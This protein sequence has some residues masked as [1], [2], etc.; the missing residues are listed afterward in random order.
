MS[1]REFEVPWGQ[2]LLQLILKVEPEK[3]GEHAQKIE[4]LI[5]DRVQQ[6]V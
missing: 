5:F 6:P 3:Q 4:P 1:D 2:A